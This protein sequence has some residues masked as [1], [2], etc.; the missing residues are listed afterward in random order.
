MKESER[1][2]HEYAQNKETF[3][4]AAKEAVSATEYFE[5]LI[6][7][8][9]HAAFERGSRLGFQTGYE[10]GFE[11]GRESLRK[12]WALG[13]LGKAPEASK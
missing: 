12:E 3:G 4:M 10:K 7:R 9:V 1:L 13:Q 11:A 6:D 5:P 8:S 2:A